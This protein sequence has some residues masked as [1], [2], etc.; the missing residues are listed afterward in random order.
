MAKELGR[1]ELAQEM[2]AKAGQ[3]WEKLDEVM[4]KAYLHNADE[5]IRDREA[6]VAPPVC[7]FCG[8]SGWVKSRPCHDCNPVGLN[9]PS[10]EKPEEEGKKE[11]PPPTS[12]PRKLNKGQY[13]CTKCNGLHFEKKPSGQKHL[14]FKA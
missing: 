8:G 10:E 12:K 4:I 5:A 3:T 7:R 1:H 11:I 14:K 2:A 13:F 9:P 6:I